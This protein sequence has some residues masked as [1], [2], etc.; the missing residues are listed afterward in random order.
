MSILQLI[1]F[2]G[3]AVT[4]KEKTAIP[5]GKF[6]MV[7]NLR[8][9]FPGFEKR[10]G[11]ALQHTVADASLETQTLWQFN[12][13]AKSE[14]H[15]YRQL[16]DGSVQEATDNPPTVTTGAFG[17]DVLSAIAS[18]IPA[19]WSTIDDLALFSDGVRQH[20]IYGGT[21]RNIRALYIGGT[22]DIGES[23]GVDGTRDVIDDVAS[24]ASVVGGVTKL[25][26]KTDISATSLKFAVSVANTVSA[27]VTVYYWS[28]TTN[29]WAAVSGFSDGTLASGKTLAQDGSMSWTAPSVE[30][31]KYLFWQSGFWYKIVA[32]SS[33]SATTAVTAIT[34]NAGWQSIRNVFDGVLVD[35]IEAKIWNSTQLRYYQY[36]ASVIDISNL[37][38]G[39]YCYFATIEPI[40]ATYIDVGSTPHIK[41]ATITGS[42]NISFYDGGTGLD[43]IQTTDGNFLTAGFEEGQSIVIT[44][45]VSNNI[46]TKIVRVNSNTIW[47]DTGLLTAEAKKSATITYTGTTPSF[48]AF[49]GWT[50]SAWTDCKGADGTG[51]LIQSGY[52][53][54]SSPISVQ[55]TDFDQS[56]YQAFW[57][58]FKFGHTISRKVNI[59]I[60][61]IPKYDI[62]DLGKLGITNGTWKNRSIYTFTNYP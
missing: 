30:T 18:S 14:K 12:K 27:T 7:Q 28:E 56:G 40:I 46:T 4:S 22:G 37:I 49:D 11:Q 23:D 52:I 41:K 59:G 51:G 53:T 26:I 3:G 47:V 33:L 16:L 42:S 48:D 20:Q 58:R 24:T 17:L 9:R 21:D 60:Q 6:S 57:Y 31:S 38:A 34:M 1:P 19:S 15:F 25:F 10:K 35:A 62:D 8:S 43:Y 5:V 50:G 2:T 39:D 29:T 45:S 36:G 44:G 13:G 54:L 55:R 32:S 61:T